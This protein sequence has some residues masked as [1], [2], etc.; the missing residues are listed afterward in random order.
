ME[1]IVYLTTNIINNKIYVGVH[2]TEDSNIFDGYYGNGVSLRDQSKLK[3][4]KEP[5]H[6]AL[7]KYG[8]KNFKRSTIKSFNNLKEALKLEGLI[9]N[10][11]FIKRKD[12]YNITLGGGIPPIKCVKVYQFN[13]RGNLINEYESI[14]CASKVLGID[15]S[16]IS[17][18]VK[19]K[20]TSGEYLWATTSSI[21]VSEY[22]T[23]LQ[24]KNVYLYTLEGEFAYEFKSL[25]ECSRF[26]Q[27][28]LGPVQRAYYQEWKVGN[29]YICDKRL[30]YYKPERLELTGE[31]HQYNLDG[32][33]VQSFASRKQL[34]TYFGCNMDGINQSIRMGKPYKEFLWCRGEKQDSIKP[35]KLK[36]KTC[37]VGQYTLQ[38]KLVKIY[39]T[40]KEARKDF[41]NV[42]KVLKGTASQCKGYTF[43]YIS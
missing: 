2:K 40:V 12:T 25:S 6:Y 13:L 32:T 36:K 34:M 19:N 15:D 1:Y 29:Y 14:L 37:K 10:E 41:S 7:K 16:A 24:R 27:I 43:K 4:P 20:T 42:N 38:G 22:I 3:H 31:Y 30:E 33:Y 11:K 39:N 18:A 9:V 35:Y 21:N 8:F 26:L 23:T 17:Y 28:D 5:F